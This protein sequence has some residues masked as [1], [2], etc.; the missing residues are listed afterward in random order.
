M[1]YDDN[2]LTMFDCFLNNISYNCSNLITCYL[3]VPYWSQYVDCY[4]FLWGHINIDNVTLIASF[5]QLLASV[6]F[7]GDNMLIV[8]LLICMTISILHY[9]ILL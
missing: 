7:A 6:L 9:H 8:I 4:C 2:Y 3:S 1:F 5:S